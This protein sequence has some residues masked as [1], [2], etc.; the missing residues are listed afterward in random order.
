M[1]EEYL[2]YIFKTKQLGKYFKTINNDSVEILNFGYHNYNAGPDFLECQIKINDQIWAGQIEFHVNSSDWLKHKHQ[3]DKNYNNVILHIVY[4]HDQNIQ[5][6]QYTLPTIEL[7]SVIDLKHYNK[8]VDYINAKNWVACN[9][10]IK[11]IDEFIVFQQLEK[12]LINRLQRKSELIHKELRRFNG[13]RKKVFFK[14]LF[15]AFGTKV[16]QSAF[17]KLGDFFDWKILA[18]LNFDTLKT[19][20]YLFGIAGFLNDNLE[21]EYYQVLKTEYEYIK[22]LYNLNELE[23]SEWKFST[24]RPYNLPTI[25]IAQL[26]SLLV[27]SNLQNDSN[28]YEKTKLN[29]QSSILEYWQNHYMFGKKSKR[30]IPGLTASFIDLLII[31]VFI[32]FNFTIGQ[33]EDNLELKEQIFSWY[34]KIKPENNSIIKNWKQLNVKVKSAFDSQ[35][36]IELKNEFCLKSRCLECKIGQKILNR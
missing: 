33:I 32:P 5:S 35:S 14:L 9:N 10:E 3:F 28:S 31:N 2:H 16:N 20:A 6:G 15:K 36:L 23:F 11:S 30:K 25:R 19:E 34:D 24:M 18:K 4:N 13:D 8:Y 27:K 1:N 7:K 12:A 22:K 17:E 29:L 26:S 21:D